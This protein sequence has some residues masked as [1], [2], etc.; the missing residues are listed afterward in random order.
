MRRNTMFLSILAGLLV[1]TASSVVLADGNGQNN[2]RPRVEGVL[3]DGNAGPTAQKPR[4]QLADG[5]D[6]PYRP[7]AQ[8]ADGNGQNAPRPRVAVSFA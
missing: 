4:V 7:K 5:Q 6:H 8:L 2:P 3:A 1:T